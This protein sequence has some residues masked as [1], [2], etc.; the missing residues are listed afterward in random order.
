MVVYDAVAR[1]AIE[2][3][4]RC[5]PNDFFVSRH[6][7]LSTEW[8]NL[9]DVA[10]FIELLTANSSKVTS[11]SHT[12]CTALKHRLVLQHHPQ[13]TK[14]KKCTFRLSDTF[15]LDPHWSALAEVDKLTANEAK[16]FR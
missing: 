13:P 4:S 14:N 1:S 9:G 12:L 2:A 3:T 16:K 6:V 10:V 15:R 8:V 5:S 11:S 7:K